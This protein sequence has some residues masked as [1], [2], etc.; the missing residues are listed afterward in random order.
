MRGR[1]GESG[2]KRPEKLNARP[3][4]AEESCRQ[5]RGLG[6]VE[7]LVRDLGAGAGCLRTLPPSLSPHSPRA[8]SFDG[9][10]NSLSVRLTRL[11]ELIQDD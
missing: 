8:P 5:G 2:K 7:V 3:T 11:G 6:L 1:R 9:C 10:L 4:S